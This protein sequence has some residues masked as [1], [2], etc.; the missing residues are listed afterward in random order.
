MAASLVGLALAAPSAHAQ[1]AYDDGASYAYDDG[2]SYQN[3]PDEVII[4]APRYHQRYSQ[5]GAPIEDVA[6][7]RIVPYD[8]LDLRTDWG[9][10]ELRARVFQAAYSACDEMDVAYPV[11]TADSPSCYRTAIHSGMRHARDAIGAAR[12]W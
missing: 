7:S 5:I 12:G 1:A 8:D 9:A 2:A 10:R 11:S 6:I 4:Q 3:G